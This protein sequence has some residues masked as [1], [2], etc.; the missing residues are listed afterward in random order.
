MIGA[1]VSSSGG[2]NVALDRAKDLNVPV[3]QLFLQSPRMWKPA[4]LKVSDKELFLTKLAQYRI[5]HCQIKVYCHAS[6]LI[7][8]ASLDS[9][10]TENSINALI[11]SLIICDEL[12]FEGIVLH[13]GSTK[14]DDKAHGLKTV[15]TRLNHVLDNT[16]NCKIFL[17]NTAGAGF[18][19][20]KTFEEL[21]HIQELIQ[22]PSRIGF[23]LDTQHLFAS[24]IT[25][26]THRQVLDIV[27]RISKTVKT[28]DVIHLNDSKTKCGSNVDRHE[29]LGHG[30]IGNKSLS[31]FIGSPYFRDKPLILEVPGPEKN[32]PTQKDIRTA[33]RLLLAGIKLWDTFNSSR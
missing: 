32:G 8:L 29:N 22:Q 23:C 30:F 25:F 10:L 9:S 33:K 13:V 3:I 7:N 26:D 12:K 5:N 21:S 15:A 27:T 28:I 14:N 24:G 4:N 19:L 6:Y 17:E 31:L 1:H 20:G 16:D 11:N 18:T 2:F